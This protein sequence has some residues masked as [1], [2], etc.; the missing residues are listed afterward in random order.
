MQLTKNTRK[1]ETNLWKPIWF[2]QSDC[3]L[4]DTRTTDWR[5]QIKNRRNSGYDFKKL[6]P[7]HFFHRCHPH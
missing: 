7:Q 2:S 1:P 5:R 4:K 3:T 6:S